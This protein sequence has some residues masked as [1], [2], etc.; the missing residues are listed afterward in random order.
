MQSTMGINNPMTNTALRSIE[1]NNNCNL[2]LICLEIILILWSCTI[3]L[4]F[5]WYHI[6]KMQIIVFTFFLCHVDIM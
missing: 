1:F 2:K 6:C 4:T 3:Y 5:Y